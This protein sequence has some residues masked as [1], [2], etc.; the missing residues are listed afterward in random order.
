MICVNVLPLN[1]TNVPQ[2]VKRGKK[3]SA[4]MLQ[5]APRFANTL[6]YYE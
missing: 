1:R 5:E 4:R 3:I 2:N 6:A